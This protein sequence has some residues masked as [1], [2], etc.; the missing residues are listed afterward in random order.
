LRIFTLSGHWVRTIETTTG[1]IQWD[2]KNDAGQFVAS[3]YYFFVA[4]TG[5]D[6]QTVKGKLA[7]IK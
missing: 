3:G 7:I 4:T 1:T 2:R 5:D 6:S